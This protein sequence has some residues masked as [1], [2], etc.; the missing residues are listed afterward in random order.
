MIGIGFIAA[1]E[2]CE[3]VEVFSTC[4]GSTDLMYVSLNFREMSKPPSK[5]KGGDGTYKQA[6]YQGKILSDA[7]KDEHYTELYLKGVKGAARKILTSA[8]AATSSVTK[9]EKTNWSLYGLLPET[10]HSKLS[11]KNLKLWEQF[12]FYSKTM[13]QIALNV[14]VQ[15]HS[16]WHP[17][18]G[19]REG[20]KRLNKDIEN[21]NFKVL[22][23]GSDLRKPIVLREDR[24]FIADEFVFQGE[25]VS[26]KGY[27]LRHTEHYILEIFKVC[28]FA[29]GVVL[30]VLITVIF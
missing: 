6:D 19:K 26:A 16:N 22:Y 24:N 15:Y 10:V 13:V 18:L 29:L 4:E 25:Q 1:N 8:S 5:R 14:P 3:E 2:L 20:L 7:Q 30:L 23:D 9:K 21:T 12:D 27:F 17:L 11:D 28:L